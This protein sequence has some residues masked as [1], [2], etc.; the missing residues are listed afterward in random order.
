MLM[1][2]IFTLHL[3]AAWR[4][5]SIPFLWMRHLYMRLRKPKLPRQQGAPGDITSLLQQEGSSRWRRHGHQRVNN[6]Q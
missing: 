6:E 1:S 4:F 3:V 5:F 2:Y